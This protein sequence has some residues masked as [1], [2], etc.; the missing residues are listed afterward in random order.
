MVWTLC[1]KPAGNRPNGN[2][3]GKPGKKPACIRETTDHNQKTICAE[4]AAGMLTYPN[5]Y[6]AHATLTFTKEELEKSKLPDIESYM[7][8]CQCTGPGH[9]K[10]NFWEEQKGKRVK[11]CEGRKG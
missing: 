5:A 11:A 2:K 1:Q 8:Q 4:D 10:I 3:P 7:D 9:I 6:N